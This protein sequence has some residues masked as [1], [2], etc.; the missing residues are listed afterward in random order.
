MHDEQLI[1]FG[2]PQLWLGAL[3]I[4]LGSLS[5]AQTSSPGL[6]S[7]LISNAGFEQ[8]GSNGKPLG[9]S[10]NGFSLDR[11][12][13]RTG[14][15]SYR[16]TDA[17]LIP[18]A[19]SA[20]FDLPLKKGSYYIAGWVK[21]D[22]MAATR[23]A[24]VRICLLAPPA[25]PW[26]IGS[27]CTQIVRGTSDWQYIAQANIVISQ[28]TTARFS[29]QA[30]AEPDGTAWFDDVEL[31]PVQTDTTPP[32][33]SG[34]QVSSLSQTSVRISWTTNEPADRQVEYGTTAS[35]GAST[36]LD[37]S[38]STSHAVVLSGL[39]PATTY[40]FRVKSRDAAGNLAVSANQTFTT[41]DTV[42]PVIS[43][44]TVAAVGENSATI[45][46][47]TNEPADRQVDYGLTNSYGL[48]SP[49]DTRLSTTHAVTLS[50]LQPGTLYHCRV[51][52]RDAAGNLAVSG[53][54][55]FQTTQAPAFSGLNTGGLTAYP[56][57]QLGPTVLVNGS[58]EIP[59]P[60][61]K[62]QGWA[63]NGF[64]LDTTVARTGLGSYR[65][66]DAHLIP[67]SQSAS[68]QVSLKKGIYEFSGW[69][70]LNNMAATR[71]N[72]VRICFSAPPYY[73]W[74]IA[75]S[76]TP[77]V[78]GTA[79]WQKLSLT[80]IV[81]PQDAV[82]AI[83]LEAYGD[84][85]GTAWFDDVE[86]RQEQFPLSVFML[87]PNYRG[88]LFDDFSQAARF[89]VAVDLPP[90]A[91]AA[92]YQVEGAVTDE[93][94]GQLLRQA[95]F[96]AAAVQTAQFDFSGFASGRTY[97]VSF[98]LKTTAGSTVFQ[99]PGYRIAK[100]AGSLRQQMAVS[101]D[102]HNRILL[103]GKPAFLLGVYDSGIGYSGYESGWET[104][105]SSARRLFELPINVY[106]NYWYGE[107]PNGAWLSLL[108]VLQKYGIYGLTNAN[109][110]SS[111]PL[112]QM[113]PNSWFLKVPDGDIQ[114]RAAHP[115]FLGFYAADE[116]RGDL[117]G[118]V[119]GHY[120]RMKSL[121]PDGL[122]LGV[123]FGDSQLSLWPDAVDLLATDPYPLYGAEPAGG[124]NLNLVATWTQRARAAV[125]DSR[126]VATVIQFFQFTSK[127]RWPTL[128][129]LR[130]MSY[131][132]IAEGAN[133]LLYWSL[134]AS[135]L[136]YSC[137]GSTPEK[138]P[139]GSGSW[140]PF[141]VQQFQ[142]L[143]A[144]VTELK[145]LEP[146]LVS[147]DRPDL[148]VSNSN[149]AVRTRVKYVNKTAY[150]IAYNATGSATSATFGWNFNPA[151]VT[152]HGENRSITPSGAWF[153]DDFGPY[154]ARVY[155]VR[156]P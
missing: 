83:S 7:N 108:N 154:Q 115:G 134:G 45:T 30:Y 69:V 111:S 64:V 54:L 70:K 78:K 9:W 116:C 48:Q 65:L 119:F 55:Q 16:L 28:D 57:G 128:E 91:S 88:M 38:L 101:F 49:L 31:R 118:N 75:R 87:Y 86:L 76:C 114:T 42:P 133:G 22:K 153:T 72:G 66:T 145:G 136:A 120:Q 3:L 152:V 121:D 4:L 6:G 13:A 132:A 1:A 96:P 89:E 141:R 25:W 74:Q 149:P 5:P 122:V 63:D 39:L 93:A 41:A 131:T 61:G 94:T 95:L 8:L 81:L 11:T 125:R 35:Y 37:T 15:A 33:I 156:E 44:L 103:R 113:T 17:Y 71:G 40:H 62:P 151:A 10:D 112:E 104:L 92:A 23:G 110:F 147:V 36:P 29:L 129:E 26:T 52:S 2:R 84:P 97:L 67:Y 107:A 148:L 73:P 27:G 21:L 143:K 68:Q 51:R 82:A 155:A 46:W 99:Y 123:L 24:G 127:G 117:A 146:A 59:G 130:N 77:L 53:D 14:Q 19:Q 139:A 142:N 90:G 105:L 20:W 137:D 79:D 18:W 50:G 138:S 124:Y 98:R 85:D 100:V 12:A 34:I 56:Q 150:L 47:V 32:V 109:C 106:L 140:C 102:E 58:F 60:S 80:K 135:A 144:V 126:P 43:A